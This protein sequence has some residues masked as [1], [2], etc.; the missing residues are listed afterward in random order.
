MAFSKNALPRD[1]NF[2]PIQDTVGRILNIPYVGNIYYVDHTNGN[3]TTGTGR[4]P[5][6]ALK[7]N[8]AA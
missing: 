3:D 8:A 1:G 6:T 4:K 7:T 5:N 2:V